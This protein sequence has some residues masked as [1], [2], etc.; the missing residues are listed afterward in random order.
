MSPNTAIAA[1][2]SADAWGPFIAPH[3][4]PTGT[5]PSNDSARISFRIGLHPPN[6]FTTG[7]S[8]RSSVRTASTSP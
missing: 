2:T 4:G 1:A 8:D 6:N 7:S 3:R 5:R